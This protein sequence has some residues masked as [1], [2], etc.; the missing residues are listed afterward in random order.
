[1]NKKYLNIYAHH[2]SK[3]LFNYS[4]LGV[5]L[6]YL[7]L[8]SPVAAIFYYAIALPVAFTIV[9]VTFG[10]IFIEHGDLISTLISGGG[11]IER[12]FDVCKTAFPYLLG[13]TAAFSVIAL[14]AECTQKEKRSVGRIVG[15]S[16]ILALSAL[17]AVIFYL[18]G[19]N[20]V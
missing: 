16:I 8:L 6:L 12:L 11:N 19:V 1:M 17:S 7:I 9:V 14:V 18:G 5:V 2:F 4:I 15:S 20:P 13:I 3:I 10:T